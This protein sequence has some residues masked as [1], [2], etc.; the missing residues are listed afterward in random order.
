MCWSGPASAGMASLGFGGALWA[1]WRGESWMRW[2]TLMYFSSM[3]LLQAFTY[4][5]IGVCAL[6]NTPEGKWNETLTI[7]SYLHICFQPIFTNIFGLS[8][9]KS[10]DELRKWFKWT[11][12]AILP[13]CFVMVS[14]MFFHNLFGVCDYIKTPLC[15]LDTC[16]YHG[17]WHI[18]WRLTLNGFDEFTLF[19]I[20]FSWLV[21]N[22]PVFILPLFYGGWRWSLYHFFFGIFT[23]R[24]L[25]SNKD[26]F[27]AIWCLTS[28]AFLMAVH[29]P[30]VH[31]WMETPLRNQSK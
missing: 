3:E 15:G 11:T 22:L 20:R 9:S 27:S 7:L 10:G 19:G 1:R 17:E 14:R 2:S 18:A 16:S 25:T 28:I 29:I 13:I 26:E 21:Y 6:T 24:M 12:I 8:F 5:V 30:I 31:H 4:T 23:A